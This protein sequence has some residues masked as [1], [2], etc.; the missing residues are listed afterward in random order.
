MSLRLLPL[1]HP[2]QATESTKPRSASLYSTLPHGISIASARKRI[3]VNF[4]F[5]LSIL[6]AKVQNLSNLRHLP[7]SLLGQ[8]LLGQ[9]KAGFLAGQMPSHPN[10]QDLADFLANQMR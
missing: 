1:S 6:P 3:G 10:G 4:L 2:S 5:S 8:H 9:E 7:D